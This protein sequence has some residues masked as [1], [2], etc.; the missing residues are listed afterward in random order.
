DVEK[1]VTS[2][3]EEIRMNH[4]K[5]QA[6]TKVMYEKESKRMQDLFNANKDKWIQMIADYTIGKIGKE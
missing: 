6:E 2:M 3:R 1:Q 4:E 5:K